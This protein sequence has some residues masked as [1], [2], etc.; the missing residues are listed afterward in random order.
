MPKESDNPRSAVSP[1]A[2]AGG[3]SADGLDAA[4]LK[5]S[6]FATRQ[7]TCAWRRFRSA[8]SYLADKRRSAR[9][10]GERPIIVVS[11]SSGSATATFAAVQLLISARSPEAI[12]L[13]AVPAQAEQ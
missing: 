5:F 3:C 9:A 12:G 10:T 6:L 11:T 1:Q 13:W 2:G 7:W 8:A 4:T